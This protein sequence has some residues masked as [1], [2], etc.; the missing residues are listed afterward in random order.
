M[1][2]A[3]RIE[4]GGSFAKEPARAWVSPRW[5]SVTP[6]GRAVVLSVCGSGPRCSEAGRARRNSVFI[7]QRTIKELF[8]IVSSQTLKNNSKCCGHPEMVKQKLLGSQKCY[9]SVGIVG[10]QLDVTII[11]S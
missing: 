11:C 7:F 8:N 3:T 9:P 2:F 10:S 4:N 6:V 5:A 1:S